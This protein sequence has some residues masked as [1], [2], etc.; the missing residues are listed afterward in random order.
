MPEPGGLLADD[1]RPDIVIDHG[2][3]FPHGLADGRAVALDIVCS[4]S[5]CPSHLQ[6]CAR[7]KQ[8]AIR[9]AE[10][11]KN[12]KY[13]KELA[14]QEMRRK[15]LRYVERDEPVTLPTLP[16]GGFHVFLSHAWRTGQDQVHMIKKEL[17]MMMFTD[18]KEISSSLLIKKIVGLIQDTW[19]LTSIFLLGKP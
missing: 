3:F 1:K 15:R 16:E 13:E 12:N 7:S 9:A 6:G 8:H 2:V 14:D 4:T 18:G 10:A 11:Y 17:M 19:I 5:T